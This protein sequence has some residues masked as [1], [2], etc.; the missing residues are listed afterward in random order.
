MENSQLFN[1]SSLVSCSVAIVSHKG[2][3]YMTEKQRVVS[4]YFGDYLNYN[5]GSRVLLTAFCVR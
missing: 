2:K 4:I 3:F 5:C 1:I